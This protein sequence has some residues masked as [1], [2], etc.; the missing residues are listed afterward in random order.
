MVLYNIA[1]YK[2]KILFLTVVISLWDC[3]KRYKDYLK[4]I[5][6]KCNIQRMDCP[7]FFYIFTKFIQ[8]Y[9]DKN[10]GAI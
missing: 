8:V 5:L 7:I 4:H 2:S 10:G 9:T 3:K 6:Y 1:K